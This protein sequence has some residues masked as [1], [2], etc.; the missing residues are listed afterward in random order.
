M[1]VAEDSVD[2]KNGAC[3]WAGGC[4]LAVTV[5][6]IDGAGELSTATG[7][8]L[9]FRGEGGGGGEGEGGGKANSGSL[10][11]K[12]YCWSLQDK[13]RLSSTCSLPPTECRQWL[14]RL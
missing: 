10:G 3:V 6:T 13:V 5:S 9:L 14:V 7:L 1:T 12:S 4:G 11:L 2:G 8:G